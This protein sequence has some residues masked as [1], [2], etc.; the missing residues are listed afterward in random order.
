[1]TKTNKKKMQETVQTF[2]DQTVEDPVIAEIMNRYY[3][4]LETGEAGEEILIE[5]YN[6]MDTK[7]F[8]MVKENLSKRR[9]KN[10]NRKN[11]ISGIG[12]LSRDPMDYTYW[13]RRVQNCV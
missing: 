9:K 11:K 12:H 6:Y 10:D 1:M 5:A 7:L 8:S 4:A 13:M 3:I 2:Y